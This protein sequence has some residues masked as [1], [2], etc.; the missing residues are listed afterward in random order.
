M[1]ICDDC[2]KKNDIDDPLSLFAP[3]SYGPCE[4]CGDNKSCS[5]IPSRRLARLA[6]EEKEE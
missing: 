3:R 5:D 6:T 4:C 2:L 1:F